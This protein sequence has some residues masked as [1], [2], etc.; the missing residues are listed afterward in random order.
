[1]LG[2]LTAAALQQSRLTLF[3]MLMLAIGGSM[4]YAD[5]P[6][7]ENPEITIRTAIIIAKFPGMH[8]DRMELLIAEPM[9]RKIRELG[10]VKNIRTRVQ[11]GEVRIRLEINDLAED[12][13]GIWQD[14]RNKMDEVARELPEGTRGPFVNTDYGDVAVATIAMTA[15]GFSYPEMEKAAKELQR[16]LYLIEGIDKVALFGVQEERIWLEYDA[17]RLAANGAQSSQL[18]EDIQA[19]NVIL[20]AGSLQTEESALPVRASGD[21]QGV[22]EIRSLVSQVVGSENFT[23]LEDLA[24]VRRGVV[25]PP[26]APVSFNGRPALVLAV[27]MRGGL[28]ISR[29]GDDLERTVQDFENSLPIGYELSFATFQPGDV[30]VAVSGAVRNVLQTLAVVLAVV[31]LFLGVRAGL[32]TASI[33]PFSVLFALFG[34]S[35]AGIQLEQ[36]SIA[37]IIISLGLLVDNGVVVVEDMLTRVQAGED[38]EEAA[39]NVGQQFASPLLISSL[40]TIFA[41]LPLMLMSGARGEYAFSLG[42]V[43][44]LTLIGSWVTSMVFL[45]FVAAKF[46]RRRTAKDSSITESSGA[47]ERH[48]LPVLKTATRHPRGTVAIIYLLCFSVVF[49]FPMLK[50]ELFPDSERNQLLIYMDLPNDASVMR[51]QAAAR[52]VSDWLM[53]K[54]TNPEVINHVTYIDGGGP[55]F[56]LSLNPLEPDPSMAFFIVTTTDFESARTLR[57]RGRRYFIENHPEARF[58]LKMLSMGPGE[59]GLVDV[60]VAGKDSRELFEIAQQVRNI[61]ADVPGIV[62][63]ED[64]WGERIANMYIDIDQSRAQRLGL[65]SQAVSEALRRYLDGYEIS[66]YREGTDSIPIVA[67]MMESQR[68]GIDD[69]LN[70]SIGTGNG[71][72]ALEQFATIG[73]V[74]DY[75]TV[76]RLNQQRTVTITGKSEF[77]AADQLLAE[78]QPELDAL[79]TGGAT[80]TIGGELADQKEIFSDLGRGVPI[81]LVLMVVVIIIQFNSFR[82]TALVFMCIPLVIFGVPIGL[83]LLGEPMSFFGLLGFIALSGI[84][85]NNAIVLI[86]QIDVE[87][88]DKPLVQAVIEGSRKR[89]RPILLT[90]ATTVIGL[91]PLYLFGGPLWSPLA[92]VMMFGLAFASLMSLVF[93]PAAYVWLMRD[94]NEAGA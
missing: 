76:R 31:M 43:V 18:V 75:S 29:I 93:S 94:E 36:V 72:V 67:R 28:D 25:S 57:A 66:E 15:E 2:K 23:V 6:K 40:T 69:V 92:T 64:D 52:E 55:R 47:L 38:P 33:V 16:D 37:A 56:Y 63:N 50:K 9:E 59:A 86:D 85:I 60:Q 10:P 1:M 68:D 91:V 5:F 46:I 27:E 74:F 3:I 58:T 26:E 83:L 32:I 79:D 44:T 48:Y 42:G 65:S 7:R 22:D 11:L 81:G 49:L 82:R 53:D 89:V 62:Q 88:Q 20:P 80:I 35:F 70:L 84:I 73:P 19:Q 90:S 12:L 34:M 71:T 39:R 78:I 51:T 30:E 54:E 17:Q 8:P 61:F 4:L 24:T 87:R 77:L 14:L 21:L 13:P 45:P 41:F